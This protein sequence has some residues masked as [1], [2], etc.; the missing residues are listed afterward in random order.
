MIKHD[1]IIEYE[2]N[3][4]IKLLFV[5]LLIIGINKMFKTK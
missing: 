2:Y 5:F 4:L 3:R 1:K